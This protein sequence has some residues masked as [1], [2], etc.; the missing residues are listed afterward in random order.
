[1]SDGSMMD[2]IRG[3]E[4]LEVMFELAFTLRHKGNHYKVWNKEGDVI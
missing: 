1:M 4:R 2:E 3:N